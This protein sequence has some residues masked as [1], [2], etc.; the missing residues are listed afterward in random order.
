MYGI[1]CTIMATNYLT[2]KASVIDV[3][4]KSQHEGQQFVPLHFVAQTDTPGPVYARSHGLMAE[5]RVRDALD[6]EQ[7]KQEYDQHE[8]A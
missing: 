7:P 8:G 5:R 2:G 6:E 4:A 1:Q 3:P